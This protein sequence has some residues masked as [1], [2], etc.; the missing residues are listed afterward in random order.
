MKLFDFDWGPIWD[1]GADA[2]AYV[3]AILTG[4]L[5][6][7]QCTRRGAEFRRRAWLAA[8]VCI[9]LTPLALERYP[10]LKTMP[11]WREV[12]KLSVRYLADWVYYPPPSFELPPNAALHPAPQLLAGPPLK[13]EVDLQERSSPL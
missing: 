11:T 4:T 10:D 6:L 2:I 7:V 9:L 12:E 8:T 3:G 5:L 13:V 1:A